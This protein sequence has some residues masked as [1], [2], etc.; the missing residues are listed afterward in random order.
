M[1]PRPFFMDSPTD[2][3]ETDNASGWV[4]EDFLGYSKNHISKEY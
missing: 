3:M 4:Q 1:I 2:S